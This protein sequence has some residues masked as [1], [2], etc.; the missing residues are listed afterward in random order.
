MILH[1][2][3][4]RRTT[5]GPAR[6]STTGTTR[7]LQPSPRIRFLT[8]SVIEKTFQ[9]GFDSKWYLDTSIARIQLS[10]S[11]T[12]EYVLD[13]GLTAGA[14]AINNYLGLGVTFSH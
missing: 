11:Y 3:A 13:A 6:S 2:N 14:T 5:A 12:F 7:L 9:A 10:L 8:Q 1:G 4:R